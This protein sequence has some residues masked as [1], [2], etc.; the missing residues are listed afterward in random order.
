ML[1]HVLI[2]VVVLLVIA[3]AGTEV[4]LRSCRE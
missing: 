3:F 2:T 1:V 4:T